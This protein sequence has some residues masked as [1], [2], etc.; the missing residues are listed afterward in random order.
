MADQPKQGGKCCG[1]CCDYRKAVIILAIISIILNTVGLELSGI[2]PDYQIDEDEL[3]QELNTLTDDY[4]DSQ[5]IFAYVSYATAFLSLLGAIMYNKYMVREMLSF[6]KSFQS[7][8]LTLRLYI[9]ITFPDTACYPRDLVHR[10]LCS[11]TY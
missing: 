5:K 8:F 3:N 10:E 9:P 6:P 11:R 1:S 7:L 2:N 4:N